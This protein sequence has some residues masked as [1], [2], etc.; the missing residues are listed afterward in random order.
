[1]IDIDITVLFQFANFVITLVVLNFLLISPVRAIVKKR[2]DLAAGLLSDTESFT[3]D[4]AKKLEQYEAALAKAK[5]EAVTIR[6]AQKAEGASTQENLLHA[7]QQEAQE[8][9]AASRGQTRAAIAEASAA[10]KKRVPDLAA[11]AAAKLLGKKT[12]SA[13]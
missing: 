6:D 13:A 7:A 9:L 10:L 2:R 12:R 4:A 11:L 1:M 3:S 5:E 8:Y